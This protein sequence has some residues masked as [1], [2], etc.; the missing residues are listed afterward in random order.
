MKNVRLLILSFALI[1]ILTANQTAVSQSYIPQLYVGFPNPAAADAANIN[2]AAQSLTSN[3]NLGHWVSGVYGNINDFNSQWAGVG[4]A[5]FPGANVYGQ[6]IQ[7]KKDLAIFNLRGGNANNS[8]RDLAIQWGTN[9]QNRL[10][11]EFVGNPTTQAVSQEVMTML[12]SGRVG[13]NNNSPIAQLDVRANS[14]NGIFVQTNNGS[15][16]TMRGSLFG[17]YGQAFLGTSNFRYGTLGFASNGANFNAGIYGFAFGPASAQNW[18]GYFAGNVFVG[19]TFVQTSDEKI[20]SNVKKE[21]SALEKVLA[22]NPVTYN[23]KTGVDKTLDFESAE[24]L[25]HGFIAQELLKVLPE[26]V[27][28]VSNP[29]IGDEAK[30]T[31]ENTDYKAVNYIGLISILVSA[32]QEQQAAISRLESSGTRNQIETIEQQNEK[33]RELNRKIDELSG[34]GSANDISIG[35][36]LYQNTPNPF[37]LATDIRYELPEQAQKAVIYIYNLQG[38]QIK[39]LELRDKGNGKVTLDAGALEAGMYIYSMVI[40]GEEVDTKRMIISK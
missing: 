20:K 11:F 1:L 32:V 39:S 26:L 10:K 25:Q 14:G 17:A 22:L 36:K 33:I 8:Q 21:N 35:A 37:G 5:P 7:W 4:Q 12:S 30:L 31:G 9:S 2:G 16:G 23:Y 28:D 3:G 18:A 19:G 13:I 34:I 29:Q 6:R 40:D 38:R 24:V 27:K 15:G